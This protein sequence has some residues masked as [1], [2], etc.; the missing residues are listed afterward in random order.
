MMK[1]KIIIRDPKDK[2]E[3]DR[4]VHDTIGDFMDFHARRYRFRYFHLIVILYKKGR[5]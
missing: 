2:V 3:L 4:I 5:K 1:L